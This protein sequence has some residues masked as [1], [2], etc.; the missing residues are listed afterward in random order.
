MS[1]LLWGHSE[2]GTPEMERSSNQDQRE[3]G[4]GGGRILLAFLSKVVDGLIIK[5]QFLLV[6]PDKLEALCLV[7]EMPQL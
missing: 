5:D 6:V 7:G 1:N 3:G 2:V 4:R